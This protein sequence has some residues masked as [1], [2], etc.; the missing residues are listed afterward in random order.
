MKKLFATLALV[1]LTA[2][3]THMGGNMCGSKPC[4][5]KGMENQEHE[6]CKKAGGKEMCPTHKGMKAGEHDERS[7]HMEH[8]KGEP[9][10][11]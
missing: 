3:C 1:V 8:Q 10:H 2:G 11:H 6:C 5:H 4:C 7:E 9:S